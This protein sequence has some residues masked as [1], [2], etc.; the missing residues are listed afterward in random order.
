MGAMCVPSSACGAVDSGTTIVC[1][2]YLAQRNHGFSQRSR[3][4]WDA[5]GNETLH[6]FA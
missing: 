6:T 5:H 1:I 3:R 4:N 2:S